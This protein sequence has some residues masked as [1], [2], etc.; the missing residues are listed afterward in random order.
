[1]AKILLKH[2]GS[3]SLSRYREEMAK[4][5]SATI[6]VKSSMARN[7]EM[8][9]VSELKLKKHNSQQLQNTSIQQKKYDSKK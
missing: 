8:Y 1:M 7:I 6:T 5:T 2:A 4:M 9:S 3:K